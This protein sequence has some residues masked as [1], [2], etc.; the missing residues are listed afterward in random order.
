MWDSVLFI[1][2]SIK[3]QVNICVAF[4]KL[5]FHDRKILHVILVIC[6]GLVKEIVSKWATSYTILVGYNHSFGTSE[7][8]EKSF[9]HIFSLVWIQDSDHVDKLNIVTLDH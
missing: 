5:E 6:F 9:A 1:F 3:R 2:S 8:I 4:V 7:Q